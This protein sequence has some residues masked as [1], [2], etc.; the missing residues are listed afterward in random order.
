MNTLDFLRRVL[1]TS[2]LYC[3][4]SMIGDQRRQRFY[5]TIEDLAD[6]VLRTDGNGHTVYHAISSF[7]DKTSRKKENIHATK[8]LALDIDC[9]PEKP[10][11]DQKAGAVALRDFIAAVGL[12]KPLIV[13]SG[14][15]LHVY[16]T[17]DKDLPLIQWAPLADRLKQAAQSHGFAIDPGPA[18]NPSL[19]LRPLGTHN[20]KYGAKEVRVIADGGPTTV[21][22]LQ[23]ALGGA[24]RATTPKPRRSATQTVLD[25]LSVPQDFPPADPGVVLQQ[26]PQVHWAVTNQAKVEEPLWYAVLGVAAYCEDPED[27]AK[28]WSNQH[29]GYDE[30]ETLKKLDQ[31]RRQ[32]GAPTTCSRFAAEK[33]SGCKGCI[34][35]GKVTTPAMLGRHAAAVD[36]SDDAPAS[37]QVDVA[38][39]K[40]FKRTAE[41]MALVID[42]TDVAV[43][44]FDIYPVGYGRDETL[45]YEV[46]R[47]M[48]KRP[49]VGWRD[50]ILRQ[51][52]LSEG[53]YREFVVTLA[54]QGIS[55]D[56]KKQTEYFQIMLRS[57]M[58]ELRKMRAMTDMYASMGWKDDYNVFVWGDTIFRRTDSGV[59]RA[60]T[61][62]ASGV[63]RVGSDLFVQAGDLD[64]YKAFTR[65]LAANDLHAHVFALGASLAS[66]LIPFTGLKGMTLSYTGPT[67]SGKTLAQHILQSVWGDPAK[68]HFQAQFTTNTL[69]SRMG[70]H[71][72]MPMSIDEVT[73]MS[74]KDVP[75]FLY[76]VTQGKEK[77]RL[78][79]S[80]TERRTA[81]W[82]L[83]VMVSN[84]R[85]MA[86]KL[87]ASGNET[88]AQ[89]ARMLEL[90]LART[91]LF[92][93][94]TDFGRQMYKFLEA[95]HGLVGPAFI[96]KLMAVPLDKLQATLAAAPAVFSKRYKMKFTGTERYWEQLL[97]LADL[98]LRQAAA[99]GLI[100]CTPIKTMKWVIDAVTNM[101]EMH[102]DAN[103]D[104][105]DI[106]TDFLN[107][108]LDKMVR[109]MH[110]GTEMVIDHSRLPR[111]SVV[112]RV[113]AYR[114]APKN[115]FDTGTL[116]IERRALQLWLA[117]QGMDLKTITQTLEGV[118]A[119]AT[120][121]NRRASLGRGTPLALP[122]CAV[123]GIDLSHPRMLPLLERVEDEHVAMTT[124]TAGADIAA[125]LLH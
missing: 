107:A 114:Q 53:F 21:L 78:T 40:P 104:V 69:Y 93:R 106:I 54:D 70:L 113:D 9:G 74:A 29:P 7:V 116:L 4:L 79:R 110:T 44:P 83:L 16:W 35:A 10:F 47:Y 30:G 28:L 60:T 8:T 3:S 75:E 57:Y 38:L 125:Q 108:N 95:N 92:A 97:V 18:A 82:A 31:W 22:A 1:P 102:A 41:G 13:S 76:N 56:G 105:F 25:N 115:G 124:D 36:T 14:N 37:S 85:S 99:W 121:P 91:D 88:D 94:S 59:E 48:W 17:L 61:K 89:I 15:G 45:G 118:G 11:A 87:V 120:P 111:A 109:A 119:D 43:C 90:E 112:A 19:V 65:R 80:A 46:A 101:R 33:P 117:T 72:N 71:G 12:P 86:S 73:M 123:I 49:H 20:R 66:I 52:Y 98:C 51:A 67:G 2:G 34:F 26:C 50:L 96:E 24:A 100:D 27:T 77:A 55:L 64:D 84:N 58:A 122:Q 63:E 32:A 39:P 23:T 81:E 5:S 42:G 62:L 6:A 68:L 103:R